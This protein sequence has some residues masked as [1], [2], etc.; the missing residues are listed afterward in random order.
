MLEGE[1][2]LTAGGRELRARAGTW[3]QVPP[4]VPHSLSFPGSEPARFLDL[5]TPSCGL[6][7]LDQDP[8]P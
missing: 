4:G 3:M 1:L 5:H 8:A 6:G 2:A 7:T